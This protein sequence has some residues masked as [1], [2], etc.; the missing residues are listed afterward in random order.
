MKMK[1]CLV[2][3]VL[4]FLI[5]PAFA[6]KL[7]SEIELTRSIIQTEKQAIIAKNMNFTEVEA[8]NFWPVYYD[9]Q[10]DLRKIGD[11]RVSLIMDYA[12]NYEN[13]TNNQAEKILKDFI[14][15]QKQ[16]L[17]LQKSYIKKFKKVMPAMK[18]ARYF[19]LENKMDSVINVELAANIPLVR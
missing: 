10:A 19:Q 8:Q 16:K 13:M 7:T 9:Y 17:S 15:N 6:A 2:V 18:V 11:R 3:L 14:K 12:K 5:S 1:Q 4:C